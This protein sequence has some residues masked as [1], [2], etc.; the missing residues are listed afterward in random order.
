[1]RTIEPTCRFL[2]LSIVYIIIL[3]LLS[4]GKDEVKPKL[5]ENVYT[6]IQIGN[7]I[8]MVENL[9]ETHYRNGDPI[10]NK[11]DYENWDGLTN[12]AYSDYHEN[13]SDLPLYGKL[14]NWYAVH[15]SRNIA[16]V[17]WHVPSIFEWAILVDYLGGESSAGGKLKELGIEHWCEPNNASNESG[18]TALPGEWRINSVFVSGCNIGNWWTST[19]KDVNDA[20]NY[21]ILSNNINE[22]VSVM[23]NKHLGLN[24]RCI[25]D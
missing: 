25:K 2:N 6:S 3:G 10:S 7:Q 21:M 15:D 12:G 4:C 8:W 1:M 24:V 20:N 11:T 9:N 17:G 13:L 16:P 18:F 14:Y 22:I 5:Y 23:N 19:E